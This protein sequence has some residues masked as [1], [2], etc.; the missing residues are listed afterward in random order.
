MNIF[1]VLAIIAVLI[2]GFAYLVSGAK[3]GPDTYIFK[4][5]SGPDE[6]SAITPMEPARWQKYENGSDSRLAIFLTREKSNWLGLAHGF[7]SIGIPFSITTNIA[8]AIKHKVVLVYPS[9]MG[10]NAGDSR[11]L[12]GFARG[13]GTLIAFG[14]PGNGMQDVFGF[15]DAVP[16]HAR[17][18]LKFTHPP[19][20]ADP[21]EKEIPID[22]PQATGLPLGT[23]AYTAPAEPPIAVYE[24]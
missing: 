20:D 24:D 8:D 10:I 21:F 12:E 1:R 22:S 23:V 5:I 11:M 19:V 13:G 7:K 18:K 2:G 3:P 17:Y 4:N 16:L 14:M 6:K 15:T 9:L